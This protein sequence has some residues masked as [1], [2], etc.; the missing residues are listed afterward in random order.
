VSLWSRIAGAF[1]SKSGSA[2]AVGS[3]FHDWF[4]EGNSL[5]DSGVAVNSFTSMSHVAVMACVSI[6]SED[7]AKIPLDIYR[8]NSKGGREVA[9]D[10]YLHGL[11]RNP[12]D[13][14]TAFEWK[15]MMQSAL[16]LRGNAYSVAVRDG[17][18][19]TK[20]LVP[21]HPDR[22]AIWEA[23]TGEYFYFVTRNGLHEMAM[24]SSTPI[25]VPSEDMLH[26][27]WLSQWNSLYGTSRI[28]L[29]RESIG[30]AMGLERH[31]ARF[32]GQGARVGGVLATDQKL[33]TEARNQLKAEW[34]AM[35]TGPR[36]SGATA[37]LE[38]GLK[39]QPLGLT[40]VDSQFIES[41]GFQ[42]RDAARAFRVPP[43]KL[44]IEGES[45]G[46]SMVQQNQQYLND[47]VSGY[48]GRWTSKLEKFFRVDGADLF[49]DF[50]FSH[51]T[52]ADIQTRYT[53]YRQAVGGP[54]MSVNEARAAEDLDRVP[55]GDA[56][57]KPTNMA[58]LDW[59]PPDTAAAGTGGAGS[60]TTG[61]PAD[62]G[63]G[64]ANRLPADDKP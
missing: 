22:V 27:R 14:Q 57:Q 32:T 2:G 43:Y 36:N 46:P 26:I 5:G 59:Q 9:T 30:L 49:M 52:K 63:D 15:E 48:C 8:H 16:V 20:Y 47:V 18:G 6:L 61:T 33:A 62:G 28:S 60:D 17:R 53:A 41:R 23:P 31:Q 58:G 19:R 54:W 35:K 7:L 56:V 34:Q 44:G 13:W 38:Q 25:M 12:N 29:I 45:S 39:W 21:I 4:G 37:V 64:D 3:E 55:D 40:M 11:L 51:F 10:H 42:L 50:D 1:S 24:L